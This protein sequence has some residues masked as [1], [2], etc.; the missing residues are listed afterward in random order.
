MKN[1]R[2]FMYRKIFQTLIL[3]IYIFLVLLFCGCSDQTTTPNLPL[4]NHEMT[5]DEKLQINQQQGQ[6]IITAIE[7]FYTSEGSFP[8]SLD[9]LIPEYL[10]SI[11]TT[12]DGQQYYYDVDEYYLYSLLF[13]FDGEDSDLYCSYLRSYEYWEC[14]RINT[15]REFN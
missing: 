7:E 5:Y 9:D 1:T 11:P 13:F 4:E 3:I 14:G 15:N 10:G 6:I 2:V 12:W 8:A